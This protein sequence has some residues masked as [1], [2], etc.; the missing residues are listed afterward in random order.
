MPL[1]KGDPTFLLVGAVVRVTDDA[2]KG[3]FPSFVPPA[4]MSYQVYVSWVFTGTRLGGR[5]S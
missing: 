4:L 5:A 1:I 2:R 3:A